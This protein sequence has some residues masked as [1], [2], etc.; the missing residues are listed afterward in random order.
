MESSLELKQPKSSCLL[1]YKLLLSWAN[2]T[3][4]VY[5]GNLAS[6]IDPILSLS[7]CEVPI[8]AQI[9][10]GPISHKM[11]SQKN[12]LISSSCGP[13]RLLNESMT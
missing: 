11:T 6:Y 7:R 12:K 5:T 9:P 10:N 13:L 3:A 8:G 1:K 4:K 2:M